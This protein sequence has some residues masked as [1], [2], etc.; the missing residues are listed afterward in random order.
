MAEAHRGPVPAVIAVVLRQ[1]H[2]LLVRRRNRPNAGQWGFPGGKIEYG[3]TVLAAAERELLEE[4]GVTGRACHAIDA[5]DVMSDATPPAYHYLLVA[6]LV[7]W[8]QGEPQAD[9]DVDEAAWFPIDA[10]PADRSANVRRVAER[11]AELIGR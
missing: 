6:I 10:L 2:V 11:A 7:D 5:V 8:L 1:G 4:T 3:E 9:D